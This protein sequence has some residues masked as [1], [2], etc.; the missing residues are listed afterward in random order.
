MIC[1]IFE[2]PGSGYGGE[3]AST[4]KYKNIFIIKK[5]IELR[6]KTIQESQ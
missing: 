1:Q 3:M 2:K 6:I 5:K 4:K